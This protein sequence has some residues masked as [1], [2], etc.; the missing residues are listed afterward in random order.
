M[1]ALAGIRRFDLRTMRR[2]GRRRLSDV[3]SVWPNNHPGTLFCGADGHLYLNVGLGNSR[4]IL[5]IEPNA[6]KEVGRFGEASSWLSNTTT[7]S[8]LLGWLGMVSAYGT[9][10]RVD[11]LLT[12]SLFDDVGLLR[13]DDDELRLGRRPDGDG[14]PGARCHRRCGRRRLRRG[15][16]ARQRHQHEPRQPRPLS[17]PGRSHRSVRRT[18][19][20]DTRRHL[21]EG[22]ELHAGGH[23]ER[24]CRLL[25]RRRWA[26][27]RRHRRQRHL[28]G[29]ALER[30]CRRHGL[31]AEVARGCRHRLEDRG[32]VPDQLR[33]PVCRAE[34][35]A[36]P[37]LDL[38]ARHA[39][40]PA[41][42]RHRRAG[43]RRGVARRRQ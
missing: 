34:P 5:R 35:P 28:S 18:H 42:H 31:H 1:P 30:R 33:R 24:C 23:R 32:A 6:L 22:R 21:R 7:C 29:D 2:I 26:H 19:R 15:L 10:G 43:P 11:F 39:G 8:V 4:P 14:A 13:A 36:R 12:G 20:P 17:A 40:H 3:T 41:R 27:L 38:D 9:T 25:P 37:A 16:A